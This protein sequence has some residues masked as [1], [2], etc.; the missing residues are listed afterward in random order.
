MGVHEVLPGTGIAG[1]EWKDV[2][3]S[4]ARH[5]HVSITL[6]SYR[7]GLRAIKDSA[8]PSP[9]GQQQRLAV[10]SP[11]I[12]PARHD[13]VPRRFPRGLAGCIVSYEPGI[14]AVTEPAVSSPSNLRPPR[15]RPNDQLLAFL[16]SL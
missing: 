15:Y 9:V 12:E 3:R 14:D 8:P 4:V 5:L 1:C 6:T 13:Q 7:A 10:E 11:S 2:G 16:E